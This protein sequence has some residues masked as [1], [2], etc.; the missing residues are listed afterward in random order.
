VDPARRNH[1]GDFYGGDRQGPVAIVWGNCQAE[2]LRVLLA[3]SP[4]FPLPLV[5]VPPVHEMVEADMPSLAA[6]L[7]SVRLLVSQPVRRGYRGLPL[8]TDELASAL[9]P[10]STVVRWPII[11]YVGLHPYMAIVRHP[12]G[13]G[14]E[15]PVVPYHDL[16]TL[17]RAA[18]RRCGSGPDPVALR[19][20]AAASVAELARRERVGKTCGVS[21]LLT[22]LGAAAVHTL[23][24]PGNSVL[25]GLARRVQERLGLPADAADPGRELLGRIKAPLEPAVIQA[26][27][28]AAP[29]RAAWDMDGVTI[30]AGEVEDAQLAWYRQN[31]TCV[32]AGVQRHLSRLTLLGL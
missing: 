29:A 22:P 12:A 31:P 10:G 18:G 26:L 19:A 15:P 9:A 3:G 23:N 8:G 16:R 28:L 20:V 11:R 2:S 27:G 6:L 21:D 13:P 5:R 1:Y 14:L 4:T 24:H 30:P 25:I 7:P 32:E 17:A